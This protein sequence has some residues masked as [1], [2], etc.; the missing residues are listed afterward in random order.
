MYLTVKVEFKYPHTFI[1]SFDLIPI[2]IFRYDSLENLYSYLDQDKNNYLKNRQQYLYLIAEN[3]Y[4]YIY[5]F[6]NPHGDIIE[7]IP[8][9]KLSTKQLLFLY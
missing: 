8:D 1:A 2:A 7:I 6:I 3:D 4:K 5:T 9:N